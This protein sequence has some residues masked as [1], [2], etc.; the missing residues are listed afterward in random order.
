MDEICFSETSLGSYLTTRRYNPE[1]IV[2]CR[3]PLL[4]NDREIS[5]YTKVAF[6]QL[7]GKHVSA[8]TDTHAAIDAL[9]ETVFSTRSGRRG[10]KEEELLQPS[11]FCTG[12]CE[13]KRHLEGSLPSER[14]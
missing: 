6:G 10:Y 1:D 12:D 4:C 2:A 9:F 3:E 7:I 8:V 5:K 14:T 11:Q 13:E